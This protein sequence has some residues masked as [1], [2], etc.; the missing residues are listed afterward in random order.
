MLLLQVEGGKVDWGAHAN[1]L[2]ALIYDQIAFDD[3]IGVAIEFAE[4]HQDTLVVIITDHG[5]A[6]PGLIKSKNVDSD[7]DNVQKF[8]YTNEWILN[9]IRKTDSPR[10]VIDRIQYA[11]GMILCKEEATYANGT[12]TRRRVSFFNFCFV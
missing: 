6:S 9:G 12:S 1:D 5:N 10:Q 2:G 8:K 3:A 11:Q 4:K 7:F